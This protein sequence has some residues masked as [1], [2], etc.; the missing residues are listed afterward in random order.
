L[1]SATHL[2]HPRL[3]V[4]ED[5]TDLLHLTAMLLANEGFEVLTANDA[6]E[7]I[8]IMASETVD[9][10][11]SDVVMPGMSGIELGEWVRER[12]PEV[13]MVITSGFVG[14]ANPS[15][16]STFPLVPKP[17]HATAVA[18]IIYQHLSRCR[19]R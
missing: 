14:S 7:A 18:A 2:D 6:T 12:Y 19:K 16:A 13:A 4:V 8:D 15:V 1:T 9:A 11:F 17:Y 3:L 10:V 5:N